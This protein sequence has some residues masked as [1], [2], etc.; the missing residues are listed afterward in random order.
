MNTSK[1]SNIS[2]KISFLKDYSSL[3][4]PAG[5][6]VAAIAMLTLSSLVGRGLK[7]EVTNASVKPGK[8]IESLIKNA[9]A[10]GQWKEERVYQNAFA[11]DVNAIALLA[12]QS[13]QRELLTYK[14][15]PEPKDVSAFIFDEFGKQFIKAADVLLS[16]INAVD[17]PTETELKRSL[18][19]H[20][21][22]SFEKGL[23]RSSK[24]SINVDSKIKDALCRTK[25]ESGSVYANVADLSGYTFWEEYEYAAREKAIEDCW[26]WQLGYWIIE[27]VINTIEALNSGTESVYSSPVKR[28]IGVSLG[29]NS[30][31]GGGRRRVSEGDRPSYIISKE[32]WLTIPFTMRVSNDDIDVV[33]FSLSVIVGAKEVLKFKNELCAAKQHK[34]KGWFGEK[35]EK[36]FKHNQITILASGVESIDREDSEHELFR[37]GDDAIVKLDLVCEYIFNKASY[38]GIKPESIKESSKEPERLRR[39]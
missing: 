7:E 21:S 28:L 35:Q 5:I 29:A 8:R 10:R 34:F 30:S 6:I 14:I 26:Y 11:E 37:Y 23:R 36:T 38:E 3:L 25:A 27:D 12:H 16:G 19:D 31:A 17:C 15:L 9:V 2:K 18:K 4:I 39:R 32:D 1:F 22:R 20:D 24:N 13:G 33:H